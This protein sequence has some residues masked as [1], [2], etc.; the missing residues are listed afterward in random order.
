[1]S[2]ARRNR[3]NSASVERCNYLVNTPVDAL[4]LAIDRHTNLISI[5]L[6]ASGAVTVIA[7]MIGVHVSMFRSVR[8]PLFS[9]E[10]GHRSL[11]GVSGRQY[12]LTLKL[13]SVFMDFLKYAVVASLQAFDLPL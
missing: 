7:S 12:R 4:D 13:N 1:M 6:D 2:A 5:G 9:V 3:S 11:V 8:L 10:P